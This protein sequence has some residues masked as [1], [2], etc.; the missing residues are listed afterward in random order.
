MRRLLFSLLATSFM[1]VLAGC[2]ATH[3]VCDCTHD[4]DDHCSYRAPWVGEGAAH[5]DAQ[6]PLP[7]IREAL[8]SSPKKL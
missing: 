7:E 4:Y 5:T 3:G 8:P 2:H 1:G 6:T